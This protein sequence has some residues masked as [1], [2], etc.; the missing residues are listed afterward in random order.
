MLKILI[1]IFSLRSPGYYTN[2]YSSNI[3]HMLLRPSLIVYI[4]ADTLADQSHSAL[5]SQHYTSPNH[6][7]DCTYSLKKGISVSC[8]VRHEYLMYSVIHLFSLSLPPFFL[9]LSPSLSAIS[10]HAFHTSNWTLSLSSSL[11]LPR[12]SFSFLWDNE[13]NWTQCLF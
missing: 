13:L 10:G 11:S 8:E 9:S 5:S 1:L 4:I 12:M 6:D 2:N 3:S 7:N